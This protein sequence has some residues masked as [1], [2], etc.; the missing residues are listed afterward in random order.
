MDADVFVPLSKV[1][2][3]QKYTKFLET[4]LLLPI[5]SEVTIQLADFSGSNY[6]ESFL[7][8]RILLEVK[9]FNLNSKFRLLFPPKS[10]PVANNDTST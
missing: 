8:H 2:L 9:R 10:A 1:L 6:P 4:Q 7:F 3:F 5:L